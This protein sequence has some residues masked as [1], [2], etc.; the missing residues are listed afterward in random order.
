[1]NNELFTTS[2]NSNH[3]VIPSTEDLIKS[4]ANVMLET[5]NNATP[6]KKRLH[7]EDALRYEFDRRK[8]RNQAQATIRSW[9]GV[10]KIFYEFLLKKRDNLYIEDFTAIDATNYCL[11]LRSKG[12]KNVTYNKH[13]NAVK[14]LFDT[15]ITYE[16]LT[17]N[18]CSG[19][20][21]NDIVPF[22]RKDV[23]SLEQIKDIT[24][25]FDL[26]KKREFMGLVLFSIQAEIGCR[27]GELIKIKIE[28]INF[29]EGTVYYYAP[30]NKVEV[31]AHLTS[32]TLQIIRTYIKVVLDEKI[33]GYLF[34]SIHHDEVDFFKQVSYTQVNR[35]YE[36][37]GKRVNLPFKLCTHMVRRS[38]ITLHLKSGGDLA[39]AQKLV[40]HKDIRTT[41]MYV[42]YNDSELKEKH[43]KHGVYSQIMNSNR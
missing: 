43:T 42:H 5:M 33:K 24:L 32:L 14:L 16:H 34:M 3:Q 10:M 18:V 37:I 8:S 28:D 29:E 25:S 36:N 12:Y 17:K 27:V 22:L 38:V 1:M 6:R 15:M 7:I 39:S 35:I 4:V 2:S 21:Y 13:L 40:G 20:F 30:K 26:S 19:V 23:L 31:V 11:F 41:S 9:R